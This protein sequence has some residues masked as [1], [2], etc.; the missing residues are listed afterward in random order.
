VVSSVV[1]SIRVIVPSLL[2]VTQRE[3]APTVIADGSLPTSTA[4]VR[5]AFRGSSRLT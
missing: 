3:P 5:R 4:P 2:F 1:G